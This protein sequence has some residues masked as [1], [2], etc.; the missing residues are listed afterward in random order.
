MTGVVA[1]TADGRGS[2]RRGRAAERR[3]GEQGLVVVSVDM[4]KYIVSGG[5]GGVEL[6]EQLNSLSLS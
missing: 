6:T 4:I 3:E 5:V 1:P 2:G